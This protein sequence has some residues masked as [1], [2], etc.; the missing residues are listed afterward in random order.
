MLLFWSLGW[1]YL[2]AV[3]GNWLGPRCGVLMN[4]TTVI[5]LKPKRD[6]N[7]QH[8]SIRLEIRPSPGIEH[9]SSLTLQLWEIFLL[10]VNNPAHA[11]CYSNPNELKKHTH[12][13]VCCTHLWVAAGGWALFPSP[14]CVFHSQEASSQ[15]WCRLVKQSQEPRFLTQRSGLGLSSC[16]TYMNEKE[17]CSWG[18]LLT[19]HGEE[20]GE[21]ETPEISTSKT[22]MACLNGGVFMQNIEF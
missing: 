19:Q 13:T 6:A 20:I 8:M 21:L 4:G 9:S 16:F 17:Y 18:Y 22:F 7:F 12:W 14:S 11:H 1:W 15:V 5:L 3:C 10:F 2:E